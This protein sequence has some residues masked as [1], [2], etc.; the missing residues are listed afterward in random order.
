MGF[1]CDT[2]RKALKRFGGNVQKCVEELLASGGVLP[3]LSRDSSGTDHSQDSSEGMT[4]FITIDDYAK[5]WRTRN[6][7]TSS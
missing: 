1:D 6:S 3:E 5:K 2:A 7:L 4:K